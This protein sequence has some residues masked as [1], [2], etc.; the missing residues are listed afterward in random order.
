VNITVPK[1]ESPAPQT[2]EVA[3]LPDG[4]V[5]NCPDGSRVITY[6]KCEKDK[7]GRGNHNRD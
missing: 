1:S 3:E 4:V 7:R 5:I 6:P 2:C